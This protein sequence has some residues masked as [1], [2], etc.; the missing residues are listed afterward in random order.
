[1]EAAADWDAAEGWEAEAMAAAAGSAVAD[2]EEA[3]G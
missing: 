3:A 1:M 2:S